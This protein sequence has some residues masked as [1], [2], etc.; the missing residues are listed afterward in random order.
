MQQH[1]LPRYHIMFCYYLHCADWEP[2]DSDSRVEVKF[3]LI[4]MHQMAA[5]AA[6]N[7]CGKP[8][9][10]SAQGITSLA[11]KTMDIKLLHCG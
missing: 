7:L 4:E 6:N 2:C 5:L 9:I 3:P 11:T 8:G 1:Y 10:G